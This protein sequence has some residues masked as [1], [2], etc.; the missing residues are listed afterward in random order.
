M[1]IPT[2][3]FVF[4][5]KGVATNKKEASVELKICAEGKRKYL[6]T[7]VRLLKKEWSNGFVVGREDSNELNYQLLLLMR[8]ST[9]IVSK[10]MEQNEVNLDAI[11]SMLSDLMEVKKTFIEYAE[12]RARERCKNKRNGTIKHYKVFIKF[13]KEWKVI[14]FF[15]DVTEKNIWKMQDELRSRGLKDSS[16]NQNYHKHMRSI[17]ADA[18][19]DGHIKKNPYKRM[20][21]PKGDAEAEVRY[22]TPKEFHRLEKSKMPNKSLEQVRDVFVFQTYTCMS[23]VDLER[24]DWKMIQTDEQGHKTYRSRRVKTGVEFEFLLMK[25]ALQIL[26]KYDRK[27]PIIS[28]QKYNMYLKA[29][30]MFAGIDAPVTSHWARHTGA[31]M[32]L[33]E[34]KVRIEVVARILG[35]STTRETEKVYA[36]V[37]KSTIASEMAGFDKRLRT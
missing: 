4:D 12:Q 27:L 6:A 26:E 7:G 14:R 15:S 24:F 25:P 9:E 33:N 10:M 13:L 20:E 8:R 31:T 29:M 28:N 23:Y 17:V 22:L 3:A 35:H 34:G 37:L 2:F 1:K 19:D 16:I 36:K 32:L 21:I 18:L 30:V 11:P 5:R